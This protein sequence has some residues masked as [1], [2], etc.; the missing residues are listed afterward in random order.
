MA[1]NPD[2]E[3]LSIGH[4]YST[5]QK[6]IIPKK[7]ILFREFGGSNVFSLESN[8]SIDIM[9]LMRIDT[10]DVKILWCSLKLV[11]WVPGIFQA[12]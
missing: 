9:S 10:I 4:Y 6:N 7:N 5:K 1:E 3:Q 12:R 8:T 2:V 11:M